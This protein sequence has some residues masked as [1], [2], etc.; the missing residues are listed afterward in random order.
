MDLNDCIFSQLAI[1]RLYSQTS[2]VAAQLKCADICSAT[3]DL[4]SSS[5]MEPYIS[6]T[7]HFI[8]EDWKLESECLQVMVI[9]EDH[10]GKKTCMK[11]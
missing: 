5:A 6:L 3:T 10:T 8:T 2:L 11:L 4:W 1:P 9:P 7:V